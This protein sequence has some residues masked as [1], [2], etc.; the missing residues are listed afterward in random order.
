MRWSTCRQ[1]RVSLVLPVIL[2]VVLVGDPSVAAVTA[3]PDLDEPEAPKPEVARGLVGPVEQVEVRETVYDG[4]ESSEN[5]ETTR[6]DVLRFES[7]R[8]VEQLRFE[9][10]DQL[11]WRSFREYDDRGKLVDW[12]TLDET[13]EVDWRYEYAYD[14]EG[15]IVREESYGRDDQLERVLLH[16]YQNDELSEDVMYGPENRILWRKAYDRDEEDR[17]RSF[18]MYYSDGTRI[19]Q[20][21]Q[22]YDDRER[23]VEEVHTDQLGA[24]Y[25]RVEYT[26][27]HFSHPLRIETFNAADELKRRTDFE[28]D[29]RGNVLRK[30]VSHSGDEEETTEV[31]SYD[32]EYD[33]FGNWTQKRVRVEV[34]TNKRREVLQVKEVLRDIE[35]GEET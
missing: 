23:V 2:L 21:R 35:Y 4:T 33:D 30:R 31:T 32:Y 16:E 34:E 17:T 14:D 8:L 9:P 11:R 15:R 26:Y 22:S 18:S 19:K 25:E 6:R 1:P 29:T 27:G 28:L 12:R 20:I 5:R 7:G 13:D 3:P 10:A 24:T